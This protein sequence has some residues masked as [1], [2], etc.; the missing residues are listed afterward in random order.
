MVGEMANGARRPVAQKELIVLFSRTIERDHESLARRMGADPGNGPDEGRQLLFRLV[1]MRTDEDLRGSP[2]LEEID[3]PPGTGQP[4]LKG[5]RIVKAID[6]QPLIQHGRD[7]RDTLGVDRFRK[8][9][10]WGPRSRERQVN[11]DE[12]GQDERAARHFNPLGSRCP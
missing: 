6:V 5:D 9:L 11:Q 12:R 4:A 7:R 3:D 10:G 8:V 1:G 2:R